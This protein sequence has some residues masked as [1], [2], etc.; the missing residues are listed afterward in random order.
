MNF[1]NEIANCCCYSTATLIA[2]AN[3]NQQIMSNQAA[4]EAALAENIGIFNPINAC[5]YINNSI[6]STPKSKNEYDSLN[7]EHGVG[8]FDTE[9]NP[10][11]MR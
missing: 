1:D 5:Q 10:S 4:K 8:W 2:N 11:V 7:P 3:L 9:I 6:A